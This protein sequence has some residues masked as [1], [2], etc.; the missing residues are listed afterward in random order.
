RGRVR[1][2]LYTAADQGIAHC[3]SSDLFFSALACTQDSD[4][5]NRCAVQPTITCSATN[6]CPPIF[7]APQACVSAV[8]DALTSL[9]TS[10]EMTFAKE[11]N[12][13]S[14]RPGFSFQTFDVV[15][16]DGRC[17]ATVSAEI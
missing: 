11:Y 10:C 2:G 13:E 15:S 8:C 9:A 7:G 3:R 12:F 16:P 1:R 5:A 4:C 17:S 6:P 14:L